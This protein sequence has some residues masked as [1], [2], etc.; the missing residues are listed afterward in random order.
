MTNIQT[1]EN[2][3]V[4]SHAWLEICVEIFIKQKY[5]NDSIV[6]VLAM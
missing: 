3:K 1:K 5:D 2:M 4:F 6:K